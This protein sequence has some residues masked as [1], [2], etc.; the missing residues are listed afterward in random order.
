MSNRC[1]E[2]ADLSSDPD[3]SI[4]NRQKK[5]I[6]YYHSVCPYKFFMIGAG[7]WM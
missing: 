7:K 2:I 3:D 4:K 1:F 5:P 6:I